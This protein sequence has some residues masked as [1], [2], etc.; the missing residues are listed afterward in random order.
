VTAAI[1]AV[2][3]AELCFDAARLERVFNRCFTPQFNTR[4]LGGY[5]EPLYRP[6]TVTGDS[7]C[8]AYRDDYFASALHEVAHWCLAGAERRLMVDY[9]Y[10]Y[11]PDGRDVSQQQA[12]ESVEY[13]PQ[14]LEWLF[15]GACG[16]PFKISLD[17]LTSEGEEVGNSRDFKQTIVAQAQLWQRLGLPPR[18]QRFFTALCREFRSRHSAGTALKSLAFNL[19]ELTE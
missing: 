1:D 10:W 14:A 16:Y 4:L 17:N 18:G 9:G 13:K 7:G 3:P 19:S 12:F 2:L 11:A 6:P 15:A 5:P 8:I